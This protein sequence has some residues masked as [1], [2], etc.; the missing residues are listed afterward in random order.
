MNRRRSLIMSLAAALL[1]AVL[2]YGVYIFQLKQVELGQTIQ[3]VVPKDFIK[4]GTIIQPSMLELQPL[5][6]G[7]L[8]PTMATAVEQIAGQ[9]SLVPLGKGEPV[10][11]W[12]MNRFRL[13]PGELQSTFQIPKEYLL[14]VSSGIRAGDKVRVYA[15]GPDGS[16]RRLISGE[17]TVASV[18][19]AAGIEI[20]NPKQSNLLSKAEG[21]EEKMY[22]SRMEANGAIDSINLNLTEE[23]WYTIDRLCSTKKGKLVIAFS[24]SSIDFN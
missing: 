13:L 18:K 11:T 5:Y 4:A 20:D 10:L 9:E 12:K 2:V 16:S 3:V 14:S 19:S 8:L 23:E 7:A 17:V 1:S 24:A 6:K 15:S 21:D 22:L